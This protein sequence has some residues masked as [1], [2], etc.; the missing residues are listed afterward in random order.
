MPTNN[1]E[2]NMIEGV[3]RLNFNNF[4]AQICDQSTKCQ[5]KKD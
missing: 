2:T 1:N 5:S 3:M 4:K